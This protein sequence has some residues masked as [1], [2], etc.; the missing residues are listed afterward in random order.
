MCETMSA[1]SKCRRKTYIFDI[2]ETQCLCVLLSATLL[3]K[4]TDKPPNPVIVVQW[5]INIA[6]L[7]NDSITYMSLEIT[8][9]N[10]LYLHILPY[11]TLAGTHKLTVQSALLEHCQVDIKWWS[12]MVIIVIIRYEAQRTF[13]LQFKNVAYIAG[14]LPGYTYPVVMS[15]WF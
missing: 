4:Y 5:C 14:S 6:T 9:C 15:Q 1:Q 10:Q 11:I 7:Y 8:T 12:K 3:H 2:N 13:N